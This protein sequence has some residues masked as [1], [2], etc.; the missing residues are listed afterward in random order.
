MHSLRGSF[1]DGRLRWSMS[2]VDLHERSGAVCGSN[3]FRFTI[4]N[5][6]GPYPQDLATLTV[7]GN[8]LLLEHAGLD[9]MSRFPRWR[10]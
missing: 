5:T 3:F 9:S 10:A 6:R 2:R 1:Q 8:D 4:H 7:A